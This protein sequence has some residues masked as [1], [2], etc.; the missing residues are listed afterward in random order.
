MFFENSVKTY[1]FTNFIT[2]AWD[3]DVNFN[4]Q[5]GIN[6][7]SP[8]SGVS[9]AS[10]Q[11]TIGSG[12]AYFD[13]T[14]SNAIILPWDSTLHFGQ[15]VDF[16][17]SMRVYFENTSN[18]PRLI[19]STLGNS[20]LE[21]R[22][23]I[24]NGYMR[25][26]LADGTPSNRLQFDSDILILEDLWYDFVFTVVD[27]QPNVYVNG[28]SSGIGAEIGN[29]T[30]MQNLENDLSI[31]CSGTIANNNLFGHIDEFY[32]FT[33]TITQN[34]VDSILEIHNNGESILQH[35]T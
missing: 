13:G 24:A 30:V 23:L 21:Y 5:I 27:N 35:I 16:A 20:S 14:P 3:L 6:D 29:Y 18:N 25:F 17:Y 2:S 26:L 7:G 15:S 22:A 33:G 12:D 4:D 31:G 34:E 28:V 19:D 8:N 11:G 9:I 10:I 32:L 1:P